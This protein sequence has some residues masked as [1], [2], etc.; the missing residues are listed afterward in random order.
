M[1]EPHD[2]LSSVIGWRE[3]AFWSAIATSIVLVVTAFVTVTYLLLIPPVLLGIGAVLLRRPGKAGPI[4]LTVIALLFLLTNGPFLLPYLT[5]PASWVNFILTTLVIVTS[6]VT[7]VAA[8]AALK[9]PRGTA[10]SAPRTVALAGLALAAACAVV[11]GVAGATYSP[12]S[13]H[14][15]DVRLTAKNIEFQQTRLSA[16]PGSVSVFV[17]N[18]DSVLHT[19]TINSLNINLNVPANS[20][21][22]ITFQAARGSYRYLCTLHADTMSGTLGLSG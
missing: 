8:V 20:T 12:P 14:P 11:A 9:P 1:P 21:A 5:V 2:S 10:P 6:I 3:L 18:Q 22:R 15:G 16:R 19:F 7:L 4:V 17:D 13:P